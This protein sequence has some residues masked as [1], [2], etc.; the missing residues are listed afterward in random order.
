MRSKSLFNR[1]K[2]SEVLLKRL[3]MGLESEH[4]RE[5]TDEEVDEVA[6]FLYLFADIA[7]R[8][9]LDEEEWKS[10]LVGQPDGF[11]FEPE[12]YTCRLCGGGS[13]K[14]G[15]W[16]D[17]YGLKCMHCQ[18]AVEAGLIPGELTGHR[19][20]YYSDWDLSYLFNVDPKTLKA[21]ISEGVIKAR[22]IPWFNEPS[23][24]YKRLFLVEVNEKFLPP[25]KL[26]EIGQTL[27]E[28][29]GGETIFHQ[30]KWHQCC[31]PFEYL[32]DYQIMNYMRMTEAEQPPKLQ[33]TK[34]EKPKER[35]CKPITFPFSF[36]NS[37]YSL[38]RKTKR[39]RP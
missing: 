4:Q 25:K 1:T 13:S 3:K 6:R 2:P 22:T 18:K 8:Q 35:L 7:V 38:K 32:K 16:Y 31:D 24:N 19:D 23:K 5:F 36:G 34:E 21:W 9:L 20:D 17:Q 11:A 37:H 12:G 10:E 14:I 29:V 30:F 15:M 26:L 33:K 27:T 28:E 39:K